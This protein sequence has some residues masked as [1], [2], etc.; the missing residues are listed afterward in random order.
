[1]VPF[2]AFQYGD[3]PDKRFDLHN[4]VR[5]GAPENAL[6]HGIPTPTCS[7]TPLV[8]PW[9]MRWSSVGVPEWFIQPGAAPAY[10]Q[11]AKRALAPDLKQTEGAFQW[12]RQVLFLKGKTASSPKL[13]RLPRQHTR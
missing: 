8:H 9:T 1:M 2:Q 10:Q 7:T 4:T 12:D 5:F 13:L 11:N 6:V 3:S